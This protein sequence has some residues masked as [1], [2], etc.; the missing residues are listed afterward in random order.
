MRS[1]PCPRWLWR[2]PIVY[3]G[4]SFFQIGGATRGGLA[5]LDAV[6]GVATSWDPARASTQIT[7]IALD[8]SVLYVAGAFDTIGAAGGQPRQGLAGI[9][10]NTGLATSFRADVTGGNVGVMTAAGGEL[11]VAGTFTQL[12]GQSRVGLGAV[13]IPSAGLSAWE[14]DV[15]GPI[16]AIEAGPSVLYLGGLFL[17]AGTYPQASIVEFAD[18]ATPAEAALVSISARWDA[19]ELMW[20]APLLSNTVITVERRQGDGAWAALTDATTDGRGYIAYIDRA[21]TPGADYDYHLE[22]QRANGS[23]VYGESSVHV[24]LLGAFALHAPTPNPGAG[25][26]LVPF[27]LDSSAPARLE[28]LDVAGRRIESHEVGARGAGEHAL[29]LG[30]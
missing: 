19:V 7:S 27:A 2:A 24:P 13:H 15:P 25:D 4:G 17:R 8:G 11:Y 9:D 23:Q 30:Q 3:A 20:Y 26:L 18:V 22:V 6:S 21:V 1:D 28:L 12:A 14:A 29:R 10:V 5:A 16:S